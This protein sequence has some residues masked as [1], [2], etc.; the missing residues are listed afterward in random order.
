MEQKSLLQQ[1]NELLFKIQKAKMKENWENL[2][3]EWVGI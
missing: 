3:I 2:G 1:A